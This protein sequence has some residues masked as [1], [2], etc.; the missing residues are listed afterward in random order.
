MHDFVQP[1]TFTAAQDYT[2][3]EKP[4]ERKFLLTV[5]NNIHFPPPFGEREASLWT[6]WERNF[7]VEKYFGDESSLSPRGR[8]WMAKIC[9]IAVSSS[10]FFSTASF[11]LSLSFEIDLRKC[12]ELRF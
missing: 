12:G 2:E 3:S 7:F 10:F 8:C 1:S 4:S 9:K 5:A 11:S 6:A